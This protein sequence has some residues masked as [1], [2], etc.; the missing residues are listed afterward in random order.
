MA[1]DD[2]DER[3]KTAERLARLEQKTQDLDNRITLGNGIILKFLLGV[4]GFVGVAV[5]SLVIVTD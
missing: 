1:D 4:A 2:L 3:I 5:L